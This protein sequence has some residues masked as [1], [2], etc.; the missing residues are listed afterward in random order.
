MRPGVPGRLL[1]ALRPVRLGRRAGAGRRRTSPSTTRR[2]AGTTPAARGGSGPCIHAQQE[3]EPPS[4]AAPR[5]TD[6]AWFAVRSRT[7]TSPP[8]LPRAIRTCATAGCCPVLTSAGPDA[9]DARPQGQLPVVRPGRRHPVPRQRHRHPA[10]GVAVDAVRLRRTGRRR[11]EGAGLHRLGAGRRAPGRVRAGPVPHAD[12]AWRCS[13]RGAA[14]ASWPSTAGR[15]GAAP[16]PATTRSPATGCS[17]RTAPTGSRSS[18]FWQTDACAASRSRV[19]RRVRTRL[20]FDAAME[21]GLNSRT[22]RTLELTGSVAVEVE[23]GPAARLAAAAR[24]ALEASEMQR[25]FAELGTRTDRR[26]Q[27][28]AVGARRARPDARPRAPST[29]RGSTRTGSR[30]ATAGRSGVVGAAPRACRPSPGVGRRPAYPR[31]GGQP[32]R[33]RP[34]RGHLDA[35]LVRPVGVAGAAGQPGRR[36]AAD[37]APVGPARQGRTSSASSPASPAPRSTRSR[38]AGC[39]RPADRRRPIWRPGRHL[40]VCTPARRRPRARRTPSTSSTGAPCLVVAL[41]RPA[42]ARATRSRASTAG[43]TTPRTCAASSP[44]STPACSTTRPGSPTRTASEVPRT[45]PHAP[46]VL[47]A[48]PTLEM[49]IDIGDLSTVFLASLP[50][51]VASYLQRVGRAGRLTGNALNL[52]YVTG[53]GEHLPKLGD[54]LSVINGEVRPPATYLDAEEILR[55]QYVA[56]L[57]DELARDGQRGPPALGSAGASDPSSRHLPR[58]SHRPR[59]ERDATAHL[60][61]VPGGIRHRR[62]GGSSPACGDGRRPGRRATQQPAGGRPASRPRARWQITIETLTASQRQELAG[63]DPGTAAAGRLARATDDDARP[64]RSAQA[65]LKLTNGQLAHLRGEYW[66]GVLEEY[67]LL[68]NYTLLDDSVE[69]RRRVEL[70]RPRQPAS[71]RP[72]HAQFPRGSATAIREFAP[73]ATFYARGLEI[74][75]DASISAWTAP[76]SGRG[77]SARTAGT[78]PTPVCRARRSTSVSRGAAPPASPTP[79]SGWTSSS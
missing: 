16:T 54:P 46:N 50:R 37:P 79:G 42:A 9:D 56:H 13:R 75:I 21:F 76:R 41:R 44:G 64:L 53:R 58:G 29:T 20:A 15:R 61:R 34:R 47:V 18:T 72:R 33:R 38:P 51:T 14:T 25:T 48:T 32:G 40:L 67:G 6:C 69:P 10:V 65:A 17:P 23:A 31:I 22:G 70:D 12:P 62:T 8:H 55:R 78:P 39:R 30:T 4:R 28:V 49:G 57:V 66:I 1:S 73:G 5:P 74:R 45:S 26:R 43:C 59:R 2:S 24:A 35:V 11:E 71:S 52:A 68:P 63:F 77:C 36:R 3:G 7:L 27:L 60:D 19:R